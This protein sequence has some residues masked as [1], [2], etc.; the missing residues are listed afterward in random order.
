MVDVKVNPPTILIEQKG[1]SCYQPAQLLA[2]VTDEPRRGFLQLLV[3]ENAA[4]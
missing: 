1:T 2:H 3:A 4:L